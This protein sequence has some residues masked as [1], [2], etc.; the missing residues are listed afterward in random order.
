MPSL[1]PR[2]IKR[3]K[4][5]Y[6]YS[7]PVLFFFLELA[8]SLAQLAIVSLLLLGGYLGYKHYSQQQPEQQLEQQADSSVQ[9][10]TL[11]ATLETPTL[12]ETS[13][14]D[15]QPVASN[16]PVENSI[17][18][19]EDQRKIDSSASVILEGSDAVK[20]INQQQNS[21]YLIQFA[22][23]PDKEALLEFARLN[24][25]TVAVL[26]PYK[27]TPSNRPVYGLASG[28][29]PSL[30]AAQQSIT[31]L[32]QALQSQQPWIRPLGQLQTEITRTL[33]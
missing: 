26:Y 25:Q 22:S 13:S 7:H 19:P 32:P 16:V 4:R 18:I 33:N 31:R 8:D 2:K 20:W 24:I 28:V 3:Y 12:V 10:P 15:L 17:L 14:I 21:D 1:I 23:S 6:P 30:D 5:E 27:R 9:E 29:H 11:H